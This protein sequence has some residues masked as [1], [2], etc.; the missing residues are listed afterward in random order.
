M[1]DG[2]RKYKIKSGKNFIGQKKSDYLHTFLPF[3]LNVVVEF[4]LFFFTA[5]KRH[6][7]FLLLLLLLFHLYPHAL[8]TTFRL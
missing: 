3:R 6:F 4:F 7:V 2:C 8:T 5:K 1:D